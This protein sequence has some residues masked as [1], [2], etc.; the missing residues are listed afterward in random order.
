MEHVLPQK[1]APSSGWNRLFDGEAHEAWVH[2]LGNLVLLHGARNSKAFNLSFE[3]KRQRYSDGSKFDLSNL[4]LTDAVARA[5]R[6]DA[7]ALEAQQAEMLEKA[8]FCWR[9]YS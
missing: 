2:R 5:P 8:A 7:A 6:W 9:L 1:P 4:P 3:E